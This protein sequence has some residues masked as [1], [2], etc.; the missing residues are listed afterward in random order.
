MIGPQFNRQ[1]DSNL[2]LAVGGGLNL[3]WNQP[4]AVYLSELEYRAASTDAQRAEVLERMGEVVRASADFMADFVR[5][6]GG[7][8]ACVCE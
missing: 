3:V 2:R 1:L 8:C 7:V 4:H 5:R 6:G